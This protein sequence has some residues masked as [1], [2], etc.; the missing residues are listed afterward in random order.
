MEHHQ[1][2]LL[3]AL[4]T[5][6]KTAEQE[7]GR[8]LSLQQ[9]TFDSTADGL[10]VVDL[11]GA[12]TWFNRSFVTLWRIPEAI[13]VTRDDEKA[14]AHV[15]SQLASPE[16]FLLK[17]RELYANP[18]ASSYDILDFKDGRHDGLAAHI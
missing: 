16:I 2:Q 5:A 9:S 6:P 17:V 4:P 14:L 10:L 11:T 15:L 12:I 3:G 1:D 7:L 18:T 13:L 8:M